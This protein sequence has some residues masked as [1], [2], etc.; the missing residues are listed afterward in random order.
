MLKMKKEQIDQKVSENRKLLD[1]FKAVDE[2]IL[3]LGDYKVR[4]KLP[5]SYAQYQ[6]MFDQAKHRFDEAHG[7]GGDRNWVY[8]YLLEQVLPEF[9]PLEVEELVFNCPGLVECILSH[10]KLYTGDVG[11][12]LEMKRLEEEKKGSRKTN[13]TEPSKQSA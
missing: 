9:N 8:V 6:L 4:L 3:D 5:K 7:E 11:T 10:L 1:A 12:V 13:S 2:H